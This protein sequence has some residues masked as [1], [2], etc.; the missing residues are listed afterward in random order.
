MDPALPRST[1]PS[2]KPSM[3]A[4]GIPRSTSPTIQPSVVNTA[5][6]F[7][8]NLVGAG[9]ASAAVQDALRRKAAKDKFNAARPTTLADQSA[10]MVLE[11]QALALVN[12]SNP[13]EPV[14]LV[15]NKYVLRNI[16]PSFRFRDRV[17]CLYEF[18]L[19][20]LPSFSKL[21]LI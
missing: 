12:P 4:P 8:K 10:R 21:R 1:S 2:I 19:K 17:G 6:S 18:F 5:M 9:G 11:A 13:A 15:T 16:L 3:N 14:K 7:I 20:K